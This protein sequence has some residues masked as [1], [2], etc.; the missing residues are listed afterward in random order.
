MRVI[1]IVNAPWALE[2]RKHE[3]LVAVYAAYLRG[4]KIDLQ[5]VEAQ[6]G[7][8]LQ[9][10]Q[11]TPFDI[12]QGVAVI[13]VHG[14]LS[15]RMNLFSRI[16]GGA[17][18][19]LIARDL[20][21]AA[22]DPRVHSILLDIDSPGG[23]VDGTQALADQI[24]AMRE[25][26]K[27]VIALAEGM[28]TSG[29]Y[30]IGSAASEVYIASDTTISGSIG[31]AMQHVD[32][33]KANERIGVT[34]TDIYAGKY[35]RIAS[36]NRPLSDE[37]RA[38]LQE[39][40]DAVY[41]VFVDSVARNRDTDADTVLKNMADGKL[42]VGRTAIEAGLVDGVSTFDAAIERLLKL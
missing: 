3:Q 11:Q 26:G 23:A 17:S 38:T 32:V 12:V 9:N 33:S 22:E 16:S 27:T 41:G 8:P 25:G 39:I 20:R 4:E 13:P 14:V 18:T 42:F 6:L 24:F 21:A 5:A 2:P 40:V 35:K 30:W 7:R 28:M 37:G 31:V 34:V 19:E 1:D 15:K 36:G 29:A 10:E